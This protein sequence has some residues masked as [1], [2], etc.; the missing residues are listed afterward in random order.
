MVHDIHVYHHILI[1]PPVRLVKS[2]KNGIDTDTEFM[3]AFQFF[4]IS[5]RQ[6]RAGGHNKAPLPFVFVLHAGNLRVP[7]VRYKPLP[8]I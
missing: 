8:V 5:K 4:Q 2:F 1:R 6:A 3:A 7:V